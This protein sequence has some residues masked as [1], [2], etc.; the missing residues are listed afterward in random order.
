[1]ARGNVPASAIVRVPRF[2]E[3][4]QVECFAYGHSNHQPSQE[5]R[6]LLPAYLA[7]GGKRRAEWEQH[8]EKGRG[9]DAPDAVHH[10]RR[11]YL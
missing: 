2:F 5:E 9:H 4:S 8:P 3:R 1:M 11:D 6:P 7:V 10:H